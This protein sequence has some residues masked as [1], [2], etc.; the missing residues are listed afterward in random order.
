[1]VQLKVLES[2]TRDVGR[3]VVRID[4][5]TMDQLDCDTGCIVEINGT[6]TTV[7]KTLPLYPSDEGKGIVRMDGLSRNNC[8]T[9]IGKS[10]TLKKIK[11]IA[12]EKVTVSPLEAI[13]P[14][15]ERYLSD[16]LES[17]P[18]MRGG[19]II[20]PYF[21]G[22]LTFEVTATTPQ[23]PVVI[24]QTTL[25]RI[26]DK[27][28]T[29]EKETND[30]I[31]YAVRVQDE[32]LLCRCMHKKINHTNEECFLCICPKFDKSKMNGKFESEIESA[33]EKA[34]PHEIQ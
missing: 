25:F 8:G 21:G 15:D 22:R 23:V 7:G 13:P 14:I 34:V 4:Y 31:Q 30:F 11:T 5:E 29:E 16:A 33:K 1:M 12:A 6:K 17:V 26:E 32:S 9:A 19:L 3:G 18:V 20:V 28:E 24:T 27:K 2:Y 10:V